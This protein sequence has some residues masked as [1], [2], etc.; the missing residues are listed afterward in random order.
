MRVVKIRKQ[1]WHAASKDATTDAEK[2]GAV[3]AIATEPF[4]RVDECVHLV[5][6]IVGL[7]YIA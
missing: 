7:G 1:Y 2:Y 3:D 6:V 5:S 4:P